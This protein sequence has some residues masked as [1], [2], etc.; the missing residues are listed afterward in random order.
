MGEYRT[1]TWTPS[2][3]QSMDHI[4]LKYCIFPFTYLCNFM[5]IYF[6][7]VDH[8]IFRGSTNRG[9]MDSVH[10][11]MDLVHG[12]GPWTRDP[13]FVLSWNKKFI[14]SFHL[15]VETLG[16]HSDLEIMTTS[17]GTRFD[18]IRMLKF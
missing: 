18:F 8:S 3:T 11:L 13:C 1:R 6:I 12:G 9:S 5:L 4:K 10:I 14:K 17:L 16:F 2:M 7:I 15:N